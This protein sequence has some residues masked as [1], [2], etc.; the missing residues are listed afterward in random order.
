MNETERRWLDY[1]E[2]VVD[3]PAA[4]RDGCLTR[5][6]TSGEGLD[7]G[8]RLTFPGYIGRNY[9]PKFGLMCVAHVHREPDSV[10]RIRERQAAAVS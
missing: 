8:N 9:Q 4:H 6:A 2:E 3:C 1:A 10:E 5:H 7:G